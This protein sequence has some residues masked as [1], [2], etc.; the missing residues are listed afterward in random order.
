MVVLFCCCTKDKNE[1]Q[2]EAQL[3][4]L[5]GEVIAINMNASTIS[6][7]HHDIP[8]LMKAMT[9][10][11]KVKNPEL[12]KIVLVGDSVSGVL[13][14]SKRESYLDTLNVFWRS[15]APRE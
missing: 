12:L 4:T 13:V 2:T 14:V 10:P 7:S 3:Y 6:I 9:M 8:G 15:S 1:G 5:R 11:F